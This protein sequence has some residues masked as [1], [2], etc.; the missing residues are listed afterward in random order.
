M[1]PALLLL[2]AIL[3][4]TAH[5]RSLTVDATNLPPGWQAEVQS[6]SCDRDGLICMGPAQITLRRGSFSQSFRSEQLATISTYNPNPAASLKA[7]SSPSS[8]P[9]TW[10]C[11]E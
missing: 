5:A 6:D 3:S 1:K 11:S 7:A 10:A 9:P 2:L 8:P 4:L